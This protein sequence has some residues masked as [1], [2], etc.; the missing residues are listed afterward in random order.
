MPLI[1]PGKKAPAFTLKDQHG[2]TH[3]L[4]DY[5]GRPVIL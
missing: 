3:R 4:S 5:A 1:E 2:A